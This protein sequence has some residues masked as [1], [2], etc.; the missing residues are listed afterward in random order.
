VI[1]LSLGGPGACAQ[2]YQD[3]INYAASKNVIVVAAAGN[4]GANELFQ[5]ASCTGVVSVASTDQNDA[6]SGFSNY[7]TWV[8]VAAPGSMIYSTVNPTIAENNGASYA[9]F[10]GTSMAAPHVAGLVALLWATHWATSAQAVVNRL[11]ST[12]DRIAGTG[13]TWQYGRINAQAATGS[14]PPVATSTSPASTTAG[15]PAFTLTVTGSNFPQ[16]AAVRWNGAVRPTTVVDA[17]QLRATI[18]AADIS[19]PGSAHITVVNPDGQISAQG[20]SFTISVL[21]EPPARP[22]PTMLGAPPVS[23]PPSRGSGGGAA[24]SSGLTPASVPTHR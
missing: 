5:P 8:K 12:A 23:E 22:G 14:G 15:G 13:T 20:L 16:G 21:P 7:G 1:N 18:Q 11:E 9:Y 6:R 24:A 4:D 2:S 19:I 17:T 10:Q 3:A